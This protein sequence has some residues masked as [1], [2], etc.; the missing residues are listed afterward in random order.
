NFMSTIPVSKQTIAQFWLNILNPAIL[1][2][3]EQQKQSIISKN[4]AFDN[5]NVIQDLLQFKLH[6]NITTSN[7]QFTEALEQYVYKT[8]NETRK[9]VVEQLLK[10]IPDNS[11]NNSTSLTKLAR[12]RRKSSI[13]N[14]SSATRKENILFNIN[15]VIDNSDEFVTDLNDKDMTD[16]SNNNNEKTVETN[17]KLIVATEVPSDERTIENMLLILKEHNPTVIIDRLNNFIRPWLIEKEFELNPVELFSSINEIMNRHIKYFIPYCFLQWI[18]D[19][20]KKCLFYK[21]EKCRL[22]LLSLFDNISMMNERYNLIVKLCENTSEIFSFIELCLVEK[23]FDVND[24]YFTNDLH[25]LFTKKLIAKM[26][27]YMTEKKS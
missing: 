14:M 26:T 9:N 20:E 10:T 16:V 23:W 11:G 7:E 25:D 3:C 13:K 15:L 8:V 12:N 22:F 2:K 27:R 21:N 5:T 4:Y 1:Y 24:A 6:N 19:G 18:V 17:E